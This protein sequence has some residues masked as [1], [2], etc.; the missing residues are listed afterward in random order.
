[1]KEFSMNALSITFFLYLFVIMVIGVLTSKLMK[2][3]KDYAL[4]GNRL[5][6]VVI[7]FSERA[8]GE[9]AWLILG[10]PGAALMVGLLESWTAI[11]CIIGIIISWV[12]IAKPIRELTEKLNA[13]TLPELLSKKHH[14]EKGLIRFLSAIIITFFFT[15][16]VAA[17]FSG[18]GKVLHVTFGFT[19]IEGMIIGAII[20]LVYTI[21]GGFLAVAWTDLIQGIIMIG[22]LVILPIV[23]WME[24]SGL[25]TSAKV[26]DWS[27][28]YG[29]QTGFK[30]F[31]G[32]AAGLSW[33]LG[34]MGQPHLIVRY[35]A[36]DKAENIKTGRKIAI[37]WA[38]PAFIGS[39]VIGLVG[40]KLITAGALTYQGEVLTL[41]RMGDPEKL[42]PIMAAN[43]LPPW[44][45]GILISGAIAAMMST[46]DSQLLVST[47]VLTK[48]LVNRSRLNQILNMVNT[49]TLG[50]VLTGLIGVVAFIL[51]LKSKD[52]VFEMVSYA[53]SGLGAS[54]GPALVLTLWWKKT[55]RNGIIAGLIVGSLS[56]IIWKNV[57]IFQ[58]A[59]TERIVSFVL[60]FA[61]VIVMS[62][63]DQDRNNGDRN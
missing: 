24:L 49:L 55:S 44:L 6:P 2:N 59:M 42:M 30:A 41:S 47:T 37:S 14:D 50:R 3:I 22:T 28:L 45:A 27:T 17:Q 34:Y 62:L 21:L 51:A 38:I 5:G 57:D 52:L 63:I 19:Q 8:S 35:M 58:A 33:G 43:L 32:A 40:L 61:S 7:A 48:D 18:A 12:I 4:G 11:G 10:L 13:L 31:L 39:L 53:W 26:F 60:S 56:T 54:F 23:G 15:F 46:A 9:S 36:I 16:Y 20:I 25:D 29:G 1:M